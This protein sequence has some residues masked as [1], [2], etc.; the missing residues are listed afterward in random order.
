MEAAQIAQRIG[1]TIGHAL[2]SE[3]RRPIEVRYESAEGVDMNYVLCSA[4]YLH[5]VDLRNLVNM[6][7]DLWIAIVYTL[8]E[9][10]G[11]NLSFSINHSKIAPCEMSLY[12][13]FSIDHAVKVIQKFFA[14]S[15]L[16][17]FDLPSLTQKINPRQLSQK[18][19]N[20]SIWGD[21]V[22]VNV[23]AEDFPYDVDYEGG[24]F[25]GFSKRMM[26]NML[27]DVQNTLGIQEDLKHRIFSVGNDIGVVFVPQST[28]EA[29]KT[30]P[31]DL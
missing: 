1:I 18:Y 6:P 8:D 22:T 11:Q 25:R 4:F 20:A 30:V 23:K 12:P 17:Y 16:P 28:Y 9:H 13:I 2:L 10:G 26:N 14:F 27:R 3:A 21:T 15:L 24:V 31:K 19:G 7:I 29:S 5:M